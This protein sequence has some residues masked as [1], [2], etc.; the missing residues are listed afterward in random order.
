MMENLKVALG[1][2]RSQVLRTALTVT[3]IAV[4]IFALVGILTSIEAIK[5]KINSEF[6]R[7]GTNS[8]T[9]S[10]KNI[11]FRANTGGT[12]AKSYPPISYEEAF[13]FKQEFQ[14]SGKVS[15]S[16]LGAFTAVARYG[17][18]K[19]NP[20]IRVIGVDDDYLEVSGYDLA[21]GRNF[22]S[23]EITE[24]LPVAILGTD[25]V[26][27]IFEEY[28][29]P[30]DKVISIGNYKYSVIG[31][32]QS[33][34]NSM[35]FTADNQILIP[36]SNVKKN[37]ATATTSYSLNVMVDSPELLE[38][39]TSEA[40]GLMRMVRKDS[41]LME[42][43]FNI[44]KSDAMA[45]TLLSSISVVTIIATIIGIITLM[46]AGIG[47]MNIM[48]VS[49]TERTRE[50]G[51][52]KALGASQKTIRM[53]FL[54]EAIVIGQL[55][56]FF[57]ILLGVLVGNVVALIIDA[58]ITLPWGW[59]ISGVILCF[60]VSVISGYYPASKAARL[61]PIEALRHE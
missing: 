17:T 34:G 4:G 55:G 1:S 5:S 35:G 26:T 19:T 53:Q 2:V 29:D 12:K 18:K 16:G 30:V 50:I 44:T 41:P 13:Q 9:V 40:S 21:E 49:V 56:G 24:G 23:G 25:V 14:E 46:A 47:L 22:S 60:M 27:K 59:M 42:E 11:D 28:D 20:N 10:R 32:L 61:D 38:I 6:S 43:S 15:L 7:L 48:L 36:V 58:G 52:R 3:I 8:F 57:G 39:K 31:I 54:M 33:K 37:F 45:E 51:V